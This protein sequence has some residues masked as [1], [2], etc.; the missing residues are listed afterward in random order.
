M[1][2]I[3]SQRFAI[4]NSAS[5][6]I[7]VVSLEHL[8]AEVYGLKYKRIQEG[9]TQEQWRDAIT[10]AVLK[11]Q[12]LNARSLIFRLIKDAHSNQ[13]SEVLP[14][15][16]F[17]KKQERIEFTKA[18]ADLPTDIGSPLLWQTAAELN[19]KTEDVAD[20]LKSVSKGDPDPEAHADPLLYIQDFLADPVLSCGLNCI[21]IGLIDQQ[22][23]A[24]SVVQINPKTG[25]SRISY[26]GLMPKYRKQKLG[27]WVH[28]FGFATMRR[29]GGKLYHGGTVSTNTP[30]IK[31]FEAHLCQKI[32]EMEDWIMTLPR[33][34]Q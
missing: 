8:W 21:H 1:G 5:Q 32:H 16:G 6:E 20:L 24:L 31:L 3:Y 7:A 30:M 27:Q 25:W 26:M 19:F 29:E 28:R 12:S 22:V 11:S 4:M 10:A 13:V 23:V 17:V 2:K 18:V 15:L 9:S 14:E 33:D 34:A